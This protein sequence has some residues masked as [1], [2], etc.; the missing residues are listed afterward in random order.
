M[1]CMPTDRQDW[2]SPEQT[3]PTECGLNVAEDLEWQCTEVCEVCSLSTCF[4]MDCSTV[5]DRGAQAVKTRLG[6]KEVT[7]TV[8]SNL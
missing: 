7:L 6:K 4:A 5:I 3:V 2:S 1:I 8:S